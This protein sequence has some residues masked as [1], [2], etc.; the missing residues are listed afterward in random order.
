MEAKD[1]EKREE[2]KDDTE[3]DEEQS[4]RVNVCVKTL[5]LIMQIKHIF[6]FENK[7]TDRKCKDVFA[8]ENC[9]MVIQ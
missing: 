7:E 4:Q 6:E 9:N 8:L 5:Y 1:K 2:T 3:R